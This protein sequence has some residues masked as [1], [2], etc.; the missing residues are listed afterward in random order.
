MSAHLLGML[1]AHRRS[2]FGDTSSAQ[3]RHFCPTTS[4]NCESTRRAV[5]RRR[6]LHY[7]AEYHATWLEDV[8]SIDRV[9]VNDRARAELGWHPRHDFD[10]VVRR[11]SADDDLS[12]SLARTIGSKGY[13]R[14]LSPLR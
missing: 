4:R 9:Y 11:L 12:S 14:K 1:L 7:V 6:V 10:A 2:G 5:V 8:P 3:R 13:H